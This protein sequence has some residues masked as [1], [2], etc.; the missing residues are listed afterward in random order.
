MAL[1][2]HF[3]L[4]AHQMGVN[5]RQTAVLHPGAHHLLTLI[6]FANVKRRGVDDH[7]QL[8]TGGPGQPG[9]LLKPGIFTNQQTHLDAAVS[10]A[11]L[12][13]ADALPWREIAVLVKHL[14]VGQLPLGI[15]GHNSPLAQHAGRVVAALD[16]NRPGSAV[17]PAGMPD[18]DHEVL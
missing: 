6:A 12:K 10:L 1:E 9:G 13:D 4:P 7:Q 18:D 2:H 11:R 14:V 3:I 17:A 8:G 5:Q 16:G 15:G